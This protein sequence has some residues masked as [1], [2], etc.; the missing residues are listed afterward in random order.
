MN[1]N[2]LLD[3]MPQYTNSGLK[4]RTDFRESI[5]FELLMQDSNL[6][7]RTKVIQALKLYYYDVDNNKNL[8]D[9][10]IPSS[11]IAKLTSE[12]YT[13]ILKAVHNDINTYIGQKISFTG[14]VYR[15]SGIKE[16]E[17]ILARD[18]DVGN[19]Q[20]VVVGFLCSSEKAKEFENY[21]WINI[22][23]EI[24][25]G[26]FNN[27]DMPVLNILEIEKTNKPENDT[28]PMPDDSFVPTCVIY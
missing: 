6:D 10:S 22:I 3:K 13:N 25:K 11:E 16:N 5:K 8:L 9:D 23:G 27:V 19:N 18:M 7:V 4:L 21:T 14:Y 28:V 2:L 20:T 1:K 15:V 24:Q 12:N 26:S 17:F